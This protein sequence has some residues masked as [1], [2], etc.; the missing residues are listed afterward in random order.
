MKREKWATAEVMCPECAD[1]GEAATFWVDAA[2]GSEI[3]EIVTVKCP[4]GHEIRA[5]AGATEFTVLSR[6][7]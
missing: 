5:R 6:G 7:Q 1:Q 2:A 3:D 4:K